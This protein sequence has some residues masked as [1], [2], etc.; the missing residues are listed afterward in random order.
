[1]F[2]PQYKQV[3]NVD[4]IEF[5]PSDMRKSRSVITA[6]SFAFSAIASPFP[7]LL[8][9]DTDMVA[10]YHVIP[11]LQHCYALLITSNAVHEYWKMLYKRCNTDVLSILLIYRHSP[12]GTVHPQD[13][14]YISVKPLAAVLQPINI[15]IWI[16]H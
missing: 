2:K 5:K 6:S 3:N 8:K 12:S 4:G 7:Q 10:S 9:C 16:Y 15:Q 11:Y 1:M 13:H 14:A